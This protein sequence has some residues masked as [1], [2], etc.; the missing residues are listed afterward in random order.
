MVSDGRSGG[1][2]GPAQCSAPVVIDTNVLLAL[3]LF[4]DPEVT[5]LRT[6]LA[7]GALQPLR[8]AATDAELADVLARP[9]LFDVPPA[10]QAELL[11]AWQASA[12]VVGSVRPAPCRCRDPDDQKFLDLAVT[13][14]ARWL[15]TRDKALLKLHR[16]L[17]ATGLAIATPL[18]LAQALD[19]ARA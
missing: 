9:G 17:K 5:A 19:A 6:A 12:R 4:A 15:V 3:W 11:A 14:G 7:T 10:R 18:A 13:A 8:S 2:P 16:K 1:A